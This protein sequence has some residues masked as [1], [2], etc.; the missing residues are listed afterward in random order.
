MTFD[1]PTTKNEMY[2]ILQEIFYYYRIRREADT[3]VTLN[4]LDIDRMSYT[5]MSDADITAKAQTALR[6]AQAE[7]LLNY[8]KKISDEIYELGVKVTIYQAQ[9]TAAE[10]AAQ[11]SYAAATLKAEREAVKRGIAESSVVIDRIADLQTSLAAEITAIDAEYDEKIA[12]AQAKISRLQT[13]LTGADTYY[14]DVFSYE[15]LA[16]KEKIKDEENK[17]I[18][19]IF[20]YNNGLDEKEQRAANS[21]ITTTRSLELRYMNIASNFFTKDQ[22][23]E[24]GYYKDAI[25]CVC[26]YFDTLNPVTA[27]QQ[28]AHDTKVAIYLDDYYSNVVYMYKSLADE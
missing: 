3:D 20:K 12:T 18:R 24:M 5:P 21:I 2:E 14:S 17:L 9:K 4:E 1:T 26:A 27:F 19:E 15:I 25:D 13:D 6:S 28:I 7:K 11:S 22:L 10:N 16:E 23:V 8:K